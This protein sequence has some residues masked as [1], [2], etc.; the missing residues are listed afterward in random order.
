MFKVLK[1]IFAIILIK[2]E[3]LINI[4]ANINFKTE[5]NN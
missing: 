4:I 2:V 1:F 5:G 3:N